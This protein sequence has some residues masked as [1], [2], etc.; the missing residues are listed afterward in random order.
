MYGR[1]W[2]RFPS[3][4]QIFSLSHA[5]NM[6][7]IPS[8]FKKYSVIHFPSHTH[9]EVQLALQ[10]SKLLFL[11]LV[12]QPQPDELLAGHCNFRQCAP[13][14]SVPMFPHWTFSP[15]LLGAVAGVLVRWIG[16]KRVLPDRSRV[17]HA[18]VTWCA[19]LVLVMS[20]QF[21]SDS[22]LPA[23]VISA[24]DRN[25]T[26]PLPANQVPIVFSAAF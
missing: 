17:E 16:P 2:V 26:H 13:A 1:S 8:F 14:V 12:S 20:A 25:S 3:A 10:H 24:C 11:Q 15:I 4:T 21:I 7:N 5:R 19:Y 6:L 9:N 18:A 23:L 22:A